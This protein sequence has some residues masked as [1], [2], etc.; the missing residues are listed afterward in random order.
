[1]TATGEKPAK[2]ARVTYWAPLEPFLLV[3][4][5][6]AALEFAVYKPLG[7]ED[8][9]RALAWLAQGFIVGLGILAYELV[10]NRLAHAGRLPDWALAPAESGSMFTRHP[11]LLRLWL[12]HRRSMV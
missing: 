2:S 1:M 7:L 6:M 10:W 12:R 5:V 3:F 11:T 4:V 9:R 8:Q